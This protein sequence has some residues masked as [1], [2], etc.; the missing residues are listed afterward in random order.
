MWNRRIAGRV[1]GLFTW[2]SNS[3]QTTNSR[4]LLVSYFGMYTY[5]IMYHVY[6]IHGIPHSIHNSESVCW[7]WWYGRPEQVIYTS[8]CSDRS[9]RREASLLFLG[10]YDIT[11]DRPTKRRMVWWLLWSCTS[12]ISKLI[13]SCQHQSGWFHKQN[14]SILRKNDLIGPFT[15]RG[16]VKKGVV[17]VGGV[18]RAWQHLLVKKYHFLICFHSIQKP[19]QCVK[20]NKTLN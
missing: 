1:F 19:S 8:K 5:F 7:V 10:I 13:F 17:L 15:L 18:A 9:V 3:G 4:P 14:C 2:I 16:D 12:I 20:H 11:I 6:I